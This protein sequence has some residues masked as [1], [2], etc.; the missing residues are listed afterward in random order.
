MRNSEEPPPLGNINDTNNSANKRKGYKDLPDT[1][2][3]AL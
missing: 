1:K 2:R 3:R